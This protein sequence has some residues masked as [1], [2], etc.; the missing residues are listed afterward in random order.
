MTTLR[1][2]DIVRRTGEVAQAI[3]S[4]EKVV[5]ARPKNQNWVIMSEMAYN[6]VMR[7]KANAEYLAKLRRSDDDYKAGRIVEKTLDELHAME[8]SM[9]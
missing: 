8:K 2:V 6:E 1:T 4:G 9:Q 3:L 7:Q 5:V